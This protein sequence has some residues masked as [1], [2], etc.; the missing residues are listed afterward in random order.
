M[1][2]N[3]T[4]VAQI[5]DLAHVQAVN[6]IL[7]KHGALAVAV[8]KDFTLAGLERFAAA[9]E[10]FRGV[11]STRLL[12]EFVAY[13]NAAGTEAS[14]VFVDADN[15]TAQ[16]VLDLGDAAAPLW[17]EHGA[18]LD[19]KRTPEYD[20]LLRFEG[21]DFDQLAFVDFVEDY[22]D[23]FRFVEA[24]D[25]G[26][27]LPVPTVLAAVRRLTVNSQGQA[28]TEV[29]DFSAQHSSTDLIEIK[30]QGAP[31]PGGFEFTCRPYDGFKTAVF[32][33]RLRALMGG[34]APLLKYR[35]L[36]LNQAKEA[37]ALEFVGWLR[38]G[39]Q[40]VSR[41]YCGGFGG[42]A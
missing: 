34:K 42:K 16:A 12:E 32:R 20:A 15:G 40:S 4:V 25:S 11:F 10:R 31:L 35:I 18:N 21:R 3:E 13:V 37:I 7:A 23:C 2:I 28:T 33:C 38:G 29:G 9:P 27:T 39:I 6:E 22:P 24:F 36:G 41:F 14:G 19:L 1:E 30:A 17:R 8:P 5:R 26:E